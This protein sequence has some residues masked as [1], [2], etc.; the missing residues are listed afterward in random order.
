MEKH[1]SE[2]EKALN[3]CILNCRQNGYV[4]TRTGIHLQA[5]KFAKDEKFAVVNTFH[6]SEGW[7][8]RFMTRHGLSLRQRTEIA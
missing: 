6:A 2:L 4:V 5:I 7:C 8:M 1:F 3:D